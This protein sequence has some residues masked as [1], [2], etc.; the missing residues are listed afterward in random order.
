MKIILVFLVYFLLF[1][2]EAPGLLEKE[3]WRELAVFSVLLFLGLILS[4]LLASG[5]ELPYIESV[6][7]ELVEGI[8]E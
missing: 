3:Y 8:Q 5:V 2:Y 4:I 6:W 7:I 1:I